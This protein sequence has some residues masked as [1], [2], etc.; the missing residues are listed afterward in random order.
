MLKEESLV[1]VNIKVD[2]P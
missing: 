1:H 2:L